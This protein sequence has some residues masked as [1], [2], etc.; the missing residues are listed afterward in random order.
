MEIKSYKL[1]LILHNITNLIHQLINIVILRLQLLVN[2]SY[3]EM[4][5]LFSYQFLFTHVYGIENLHKTVNLRHQILT[6]LNLVFFVKTC[7]IIFI[8]SL[9]FYRSNLKLANKKHTAG[10]KQL[11]GTI[12]GFIVFQVFIIGN[13]TTQ[14]RFYRKP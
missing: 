6:K 10:P 5:F 9:N 3:F 1:N 12:P 8:N 14:P 7:K 13:F 11:L 2:E 4:L